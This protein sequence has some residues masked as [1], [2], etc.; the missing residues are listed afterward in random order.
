MCLVNIGTYEKL[1]TGNLKY[2]KSVDMDSNYLCLHLA[3]NL[4]V[5]GTTSV[6]SVRQVFRLCF[7]LL[8]F[9]VLRQVFDVI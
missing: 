3:S 4:H 2:G 5:D 1:T 9:V 7:T 6:Q 8:C